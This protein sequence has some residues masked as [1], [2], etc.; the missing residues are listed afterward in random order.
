MQ[1][2]G[3]SADPEQHFL[4]D[5]LDHKSRHDIARLNYLELQTALN[6]FGPTLFKHDQFRAYYKQKDL[7]HRRLF[8]WL[9]SVHS[10]V[11][12]SRQLISDKRFSDDDRLL[13]KTTFGSNQAIFFNEFRHLMIH[14]FLPTTTGHHVASL[15]PK[16]GARSHTSLVFLIQEQL[17]PAFEE[18]LVLAKKPNKIS[19]LKAA[20]A[21][22]RSRPKKMDLATEAGTYAKVIDNLIASLRA[23]TESISSEVKDAL[24]AVENPE[25]ILMSDDA[26]RYFETDSSA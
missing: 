20:I 16:E 11:E 17:L 10:L 5:A 4:Y 13:V 22:L 7:V 9:A 14:Q 24:H 23:R 15:P 6:G 12:S 26:K 18:R 21:H 3:I 1:K 25:P 8:N 19:A 2:N